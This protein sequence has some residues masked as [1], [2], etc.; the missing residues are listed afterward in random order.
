MKKIDKFIDATSSNPETLDKIIEYVLNTYH[1][2][3]VEE[4]AIAYATCLNPNLSEDQ[5]LRLAK[6]FPYLIKHNTSFKL[7]AISN[8]DESFIEIS[9]SNDKEMYVES[10]IYNEEL[11][12][13][14][15]LKV[16]LLQQEIIF[17]T[18]DYAFKA[19]KELLKICPKAMQAKFIKKSK[20]KYLIQE[21][22]K[23]TLKYILYMCKYSESKGNF[24]LED[25]S[26]M[27]FSYFK[28]HYEKMFFKELLKD[29]HKSCLNIFIK[30]SLKYL[31]YIYK[32]NSNPFALKEAEKI[33]S[34]FLDYEYDRV[35]LTPFF[36]GKLKEKF[37]NKGTHVYFDSRF[38][39]E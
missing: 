5:M 1:N 18:E 16:A 37:Q 35:D 36:D 27:D 24:K 22:N 15:T 11:Q 17:S 28:D 10:W 31:D 33:C 8:P 30:N 20:E 26:L 2:Y 7:F 14:S 21:F 34:K 3:D 9:K 38:S 29:N 25:Y 6:K 39:E 32:T 19:G 23:K 12:N 13:F 4:H